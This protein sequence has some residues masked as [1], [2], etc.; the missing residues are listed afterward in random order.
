MKTKLIVTTALLLGSAALVDAEDRSRTQS[1]LDAMKM[2]WKY[3]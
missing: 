1:L 2:S 3:Y